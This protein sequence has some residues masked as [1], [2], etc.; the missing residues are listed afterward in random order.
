MTTTLFDFKQISPDIDG[1]RFMSFGGGY[2]SEVAH[3]STRVDA[4]G[5]GGTMSVS[6]LREL[7]EFSRPGYAMIGG[8][9]KSLKHSKKKQNKRRRT[10][11]YT[12]K[13]Q[14]RLKCLWR[15]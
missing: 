14:S 2:P 12:R 7:Q 3:D 4:I 6:K 15:R 10:H 1:P 8:A 13:S 5:A 9:R 11:R